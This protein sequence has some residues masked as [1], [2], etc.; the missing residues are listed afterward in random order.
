VILVLE[1]D[2]VEA[3]RQHRGPV[4]DDFLKEFVRPYQTALSDFD[5]FTVE[6]I[7]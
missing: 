2:S 6:E 5:H 7:S 4:M 1:W 3:H